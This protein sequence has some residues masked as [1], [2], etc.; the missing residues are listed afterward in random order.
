MRQTGNRHCH[1]PYFPRCARSVAGNILIRFAAICAAKEI[2][3]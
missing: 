2:R 3:I 1:G